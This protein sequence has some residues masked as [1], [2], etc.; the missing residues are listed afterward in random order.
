MNGKSNG[1]AAGN[2]ALA[3]P[4]KISISLKISG[5]KHKIEVAL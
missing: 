5:T 1:E 4:A 2:G 3:L